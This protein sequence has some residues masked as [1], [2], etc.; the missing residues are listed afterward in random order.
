M[1]VSNTTKLGIAIPVPGSAEPFRVAQYN[2]AISTLDAAAGVT[3]VASE[4]ARPAAPFEGQL[5][6]QQDTAETFVWATV[7]GETAWQPA[8]G[9]GG[10]SVTVADSAPLAADSESGDL[11]W[12][13]TDG[14]MYV[15]YVDENGTQQWIGVIPGGVTNTDGNE[16]TRFYVG[17]IDPQTDF[18]AVLTAGDVWIQAP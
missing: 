10:A 4:E 18:S 1:A 5:I 6:F 9:G 16:G 2:A 3:T 14:T 17:N 15:F 13:S 11:W 12:D 8:G 7:E